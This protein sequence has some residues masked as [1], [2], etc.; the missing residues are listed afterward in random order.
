MLTDDSFGISYLNQGL[1]FGGRK[2][3]GYGRF[4]GPEG[5]LG[6]T[7]PKAIT[8]DA[9]FGVVQTSIPPVVDYPVRDTQR[10]WTCTYEDAWHSK[11]ARKLGTLLTHTRTHTVL[12]SLVRLAFGSLVQRIHAIRGLL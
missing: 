9:W 5:L 12:H 2:H 10:S 11:A 7:A 6:L 3:S 4:G 1:P 8:E